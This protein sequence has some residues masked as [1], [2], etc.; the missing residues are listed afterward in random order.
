MSLN[1]LVRPWMV[2]WGLEWSY[3]AMHNFWACFNKFFICFRYLVVC[4]ASQ[5]LGAENR[6]G[7]YIEL[8][9]AFL[10]SGFG[11][12]SVF[13]GNN[14]HILLLCMG[15]E[16]SFKYDFNNIFLA[17]DGGVAFNM[18]I[19]H[20]FRLSFNILLFIYVIIVPFLYY[21]IF[22]FRKLQTNRIQDVY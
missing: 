20:P 7:N 8:A 14:S 3:T 15:R 11:S 5:I 21:K 9:I 22:K 13:Y 10:S 16:E 17:Y 1:G 4:C 12:I 19:I 6:I 2:L 18:R